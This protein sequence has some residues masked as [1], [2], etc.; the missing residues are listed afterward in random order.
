MNAEEETIE[1]KDIIELLD[2]KY[3]LVIA[4]YDSNFDE[5][6]DVVEKAIKSQDWQ[7]LNERVDE[8]YMDASDYGLDYAFRELKKEM[9]REFDVEEDEAEELIEQHR[10]EIMEE[11]QNRDN[12]N[13]MNDM[14]RHTSDPVMFYDTGEEI[15]FD[16]PF[17]TEQDMKEC[18]K[19]I[20]K[21]L[22]IKL[23]EKKYDA[24]LKMMIE[25]GYFG[26]L[27]I[28]FTVDIKAMMNLKDDNVISFENPVVAIINTWQG[29]GDH[30]ELIGHK[31]SLPLNLNN[32]FMDRCVHYSYTYE[33]CGMY[34]NWCDGTI[35]HFKKQ[36][37]FKPVKSS[38]LN[39]DKAIEDE[40]KKTFL[41]G[42]CTFGDMNMRRH[43]GT[44]Y[45]NEFPCGT[46]CPHCHTFWID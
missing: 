9:C 42:K 26:R 23:S 34:S 13:V 3:E 12:S 31:F 33:V 16:I 7:P 45:L 35:V 32:L 1:L 46:H 40:Y 37:I 25:Q 41:E 17:G 43:R 18:L 4:D 19:Q 2:K 6:L 36:K 30:C 5:N 20:K 28:Y 24:T 15:N 39:E 11:I 8:W 29:S 27:V 44:Y 14:I 38:S 10:D 22:K 21:A